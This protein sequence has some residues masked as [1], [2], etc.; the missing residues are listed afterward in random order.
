MP[1][2][3]DEI[4]VRKDSLKVEIDEITKDHKKQVCIVFYCSFS[5][6]FIA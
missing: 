3:D 2:D 5:I 1:T 6:S 4:E